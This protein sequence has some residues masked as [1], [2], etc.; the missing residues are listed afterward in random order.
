MKKIIAVIGALFMCSVVWDQPTTPVNM[1]VTAEAATVKTPSPTGL[2]ATVSVSTVRL[3][4]NKVKG[5]DGYRVY[6]YDSKD[7]KYKKYRDVVGTKCVLKELPANTYYIKVA[8]VKNGKAGTKSSKVKVV[9]AVSTEK[10]VNMYKNVIA[11]YRNG[12]NDLID[13]NVDV[14]DIMCSLYDITGDGIPELFISEGDY[15]ASGV[16][17]YSYSKDKLIQFTSRNDDNEVFYTFGGWGEVTYCPK[18][19]LLIVGYGNASFVTNFYEYK[20]GSLNRAISLLDNSQAGY[21]PEYSVNGKAVTKEEYD[22]IYKKY[23]G[24]CIGLGKSFSIDP[25]DGKDKDKLSIDEVWKKILDENW[26][27]YKD[28]YE[29]I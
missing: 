3:T 13:P 17:I 22:A 27:G 20:N 16:H 5:A 10:W 29:V 21:T 28:C 24:E 18:T 9:T 15:H 6:I 25:T 12:T 7:K 8:V 11:E 2:E 23:Y 19:R 1:S 14:G 26:T 4:W